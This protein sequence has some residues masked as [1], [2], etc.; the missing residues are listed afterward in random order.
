MLLNKNDN[1]ELYP[2]AF[3]FYVTIMFNIQK[4]ANFKLL[5]WQ[6]G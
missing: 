3:E 2:C 4:K 6:N 5:K 1:I